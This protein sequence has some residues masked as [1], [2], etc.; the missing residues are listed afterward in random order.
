MS[1]ARAA[2]AP[3]VLKAATYRAYAKIN[4]YL[5]VLDRRPDG[6]TNIETVFQSIELWDELHV[7]PADAGTAF[8]CS[9]PA[10]A[11]PAGNLVPRAAALLRGRTGTARG[12]ALHL[13]KGI[14][15]AAGLAGG[16]ADAAAA[17]VALN[18]L[19]ELALPPAE[20]AELAA[21][22]GS[23]VPFCL[24]GGTAAAT[25][26]GE[27]LEPLPAV[28]PQ[29]LVLLHPPFGV[30]AAQAYG[31]P[32]LAR[33]PERPE[34]GKT[35]SFRAALDR[36]AAGRVPEMIFNRMESAIFHDHPALARATAA[37]REAGCSAAA[38]S[39]SGPTLFGLCAGEAQAR[40]VGSRAPYPASVVRTA[41]R[42]VVRRA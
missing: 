37:L 6:F 39:G 20:L 25:G 34:D 32:A 7:T 15:V 27:V 33:S 28:A 26:R 13:E 8:T 1:A 14:P 24:T 22:L 4:L 12:A 42:G 35:P 23:D 36:L 9:D 41:P 31:H 17:L 10:L 3:D 19:W 30:T 29:W 18:D 5:D 11:D 40:A 2:G 38:M 21:E 16:S